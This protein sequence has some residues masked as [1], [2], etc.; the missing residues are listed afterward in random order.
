MED[1]VRC[2]SLAAVVTARAKRGSGV[3]YSVILR[4]VGTGGH[5]RHSNLWQERLPAIER[6]REI[7][8]E[9]T[10]MMNLVPAH[11]DDT[12]LIDSDARSEG[13]RGF[14]MIQ[15]QGLRPRLASVV[16]TLN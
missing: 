16:R 1:A 14:A 15:D 5:A 12:V 13:M 4:C 6:T 11:T 9:A 8:I 7:D 3:K 2:G 10:L